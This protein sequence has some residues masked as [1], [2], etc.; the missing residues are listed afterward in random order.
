VTARTALVVERF[1]AGVDHV[2]LISHPRIGTLDRFSVFRTLEELLG[3][4][5]VLPHTVTGELAATGRYR[6]REFYCAGCLL[7]HPDQ[8]SSEARETRDRAPT[9]QA[10]RDLR[11]V[12]SWALRGSAWMEGLRR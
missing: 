4:I 9:A 5:A 12:N 2:K 6:K 1:A 8:H 11:T 10:E 3:S 7:E